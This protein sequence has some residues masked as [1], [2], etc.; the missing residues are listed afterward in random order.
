MRK[1]IVP[2]SLM[3][4]HGMEVRWSASVWM[5]TSLGHHAT[6]SIQVVRLERQS[7]PFFAGCQLRSS[8]CHTKRKMPGRVYQEVLLV[9]PFSACSWS[10]PAYGG[11]LFTAEKCEPMGLPSCRTN[12]T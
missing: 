5:R 2:Q 12:S 8:F 1:F 3:V 9:S 7:N 11:D 6:D 10:A 4:T